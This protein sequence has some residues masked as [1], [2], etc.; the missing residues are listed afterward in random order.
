M[1]SV[2]EILEL[3]GSILHGKCINGIYN[4]EYNRYEGVKVAL[5]SIRMQID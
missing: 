5:N 1:L 4:M 3:R 2:D